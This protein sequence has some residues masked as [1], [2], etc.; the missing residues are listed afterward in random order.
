MIAYASYQTD[1][2]IKNYVDALIKAGHEVDIF[3]LGPPGAPQDGISLF[4]LMSKVW[5]KNPIIY[6]VSQTLFLIL[7]TLHVGARFFRRRYRLIHVHNLPDFLVFSAVIP[8]LFGTSV[9]LDIHDTMP[10]SYATKFD[11]DLTH[12]LISALRVE[13][14][15]SAAFSD[16]IIT[17][18]ELHK[19]ALISHGIPCD[20]ISVIMNVANERI[21]RPRSRPLTSPGLTL[22]YHGT[23]AARLGLDIILEAIHLARSSC[24]ELRFL[25]IGDGDYMPTVRWLITQRGLENTVHIEPWVPVERLSDYLAVADI[26]V[27]GNRRYTEVRQ[28]WMLPVKMLEYAAMEI[29]TIAPRLKVI[30]HYFDDTNAILYEPDDPTDMAQC[31]RSVYAD[32]GQLEG[33]KQGLR[34]FNTRYNW[35]S[36]ERQYLNLVTSLTKARRS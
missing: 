26:G 9:I 27:V 1:A 2:R 24:P 12:P 35:S 23:V 32:R 20:K 31:I 17:T 30:R 15:L 18:N 22:A 11:L 6:V 7:A 3:A 5:S 8:R 21:F 16:S 10:E 4:C 19:N 13:E 25:L 33:L 28:N 29:P 36:M 34:R 14:R